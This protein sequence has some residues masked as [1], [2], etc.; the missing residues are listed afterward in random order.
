MKF[1]MMLRPEPEPTWA[2]AKQAGVDYAV[3][4][5]SRLPGGQPPGYASLSKLKASFAEHGLDLIVLEGDPFPMDRIK[6]GL[7]GRDEDIARYCE[8][9]QAMGRLDIGVMCCNFMA[10]IGWFRTSRTVRTRGGALATSFDFEQVKNAPLTPAGVVE[11]ERLWDNLAYF[12]ERVL[13]AAEAANVKLALHPDDPPVSPLRGVGR[14]LTSPAAFRRALSL[15]PSKCHGVSFC[16]GTFATMGVDI[17]ETIR[18]FGRRGEV[19]FVHFRDVRGTAV[20]FEETFHDA[21]QTDMLRAMRCY[22]EVGFDGPI[23]P[24]HAPTMEGE[25]NDRPGYAAIGRIFA[26]GYMKG[27]LESLK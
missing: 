20:R 24:D 15:F 27:L 7:P 6:L 3:T 19:F 17:Y 25:S 2:L 13:P 22:V 12:L 14:I 10:Q 8:L 21:G 11:E 26:I 9:L 1:C 18:E 23:R 5:P 16:Q 4:N